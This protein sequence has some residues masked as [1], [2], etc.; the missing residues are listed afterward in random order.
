MARRNV[1]LYEIQA[2]V[3]LAIGEFML[4]FLNSFA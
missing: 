2:P 4:F 1:Y 3:T